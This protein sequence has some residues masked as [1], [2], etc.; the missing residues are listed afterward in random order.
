MKNKELLASGRE[1]DACGF[2]AAHKTDPVCKTIA[3]CGNDCGACPRHLPKTPAQLRRTAQLWYR[4][5]YRDH[6]VDNQ[7]I[8]CMGCTPENWCRYEI[9]ACTRRHGIENCGF[10]P[11]YPCKTLESAFVQTMCFEPACRRQCTGEEYAQLRR[12]FFEK[13][14]NLNA[15]R[16]NAK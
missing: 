5:G 13:Q 16:T 11:D 9:A 14:T 7:E 15:V 12:A 2:A 4:I 1:A 8:Q 6:V 3:A 10:C